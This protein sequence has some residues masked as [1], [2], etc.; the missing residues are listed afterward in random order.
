MHEKNEK[1]NIRRVLKQR[2]RPDQP[3]RVSEL[4]SFATRQK[5]PDFLHDR[6]LLRSMI[7]TTSECAIG[8]GLNLG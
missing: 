2:K 5:E 4:V 6:G 1:R 7:V 8:I 3:A